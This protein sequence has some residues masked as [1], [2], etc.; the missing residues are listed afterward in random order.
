MVARGV[1]S[2]A[3]TCFGSGHSSRSPPPASSSVPC[4]VSPGRP[5]RFSDE[6]PPPPEQDVRAAH[7]HRMF[8]T[9]EAVHPSGPSH[10]AA[11]EGDGP[12]LSASLVSTARPPPVA[13][14]GLELVLLPNCSPSPHRCETCA[15]SAAR[16]PWSAACWARPTLSA[17]LRSPSRKRGRCLRHPPGSASGNPRRCL[18]H[19][20][21]PRRLLLTQPRP[22]RCR[23]GFL[24]SAS[25]TR[26]QGKKTPRSACR[27]ARP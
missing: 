6:A 10:T 17:S 1:L 2:P 9:H 4:R 26:S 11:G 8:H 3:V 27:S 25:W 16:R 13:I 18:R 7:V 5:S 23:R 20:P 21:W 19:L 12:E 22:Q 15:P 14:G 24:H